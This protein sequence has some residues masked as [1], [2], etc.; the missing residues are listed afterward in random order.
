MTSTNSNRDK[1]NRDT[2]TPEHISEVATEVA[3]HTLE[4]DFDNYVHGEHP[5]AVQG[6]LTIEDERFTAEA[7]HH[8]DRAIASQSSD[9]LLAYG[10][11]TPIPSLDEI[12]SETL[13]DT[14]V[15]RAQSDPGAYAYLALEFY[16]QTGEERY[17]TAARKQYEFFETAL[18][19]TDGGI[20]HHRDEVELWV[21]SLY[22]IP[23]FF[24]R[25]GQLFETP[26]AVDEALHQILVQ[27]EYLQEE[28]TGLFRHIWRETPDTFP[29]SSFWSRG[30]GWAATGIVDALE[31]VSEDHEKYDQAVAVL[32]ELF[33]AVVP[34]QDASGFWH[35]ILDDTD[36][37]LETSGT[38][39]FAYAIQKSAELGIHSNDDYLNAARDGFEASVGVVREGKVRRT[40]QT[41]GG[42]S[43]PLGVT[44]YGQGF[45]MLAADA[46]S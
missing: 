23:P 21:D 1:G 7:R 43:A 6:L 46:F 11:I 36:S 22:M 28:R 30:N 4:I 41:P 8:V 35:N 16:E 44:L 42:P 45:F 33:D 31:Y 37:Y 19:T 38:L 34:R 27:A 15:Y 10:S 12:G 18:R 14:N 20:S 40:A 5:M 9:G 39:M 29:D 26:D 32:L 13:L 17:R 3:A 24:A 25:Y 2:I